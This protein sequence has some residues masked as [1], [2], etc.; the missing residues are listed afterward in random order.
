MVFSGTFFRT[1]S[2]SDSAVTSADG[3]LVG[4]GYP[5]IPG[6]VGSTDVE[7]ENAGRSSPC[8]RGVANHCSRQR[9][10]NRH[11]QG[12]GELNVGAQSNGFLR[13]VDVLLAVG[14]HVSREQFEYLASKNSQHL[15]LQLV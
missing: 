14:I 13:A 8:E 1:K 5:A 10:R 2:A 3:R 4:A 12:N 6:A 7:N 15:Y 11:P 9:L